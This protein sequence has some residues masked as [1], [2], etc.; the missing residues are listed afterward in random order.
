MVAAARE[1]GAYIMWFDVPGYRYG[2][3]V[4]GSTQVALKRVCTE[5]VLKAV[6]GTLDYGTP[7][8]LGITDDAVGFAFDGIPASVPASV[9]ERQKQLIDA[10]KAGSLVLKAGE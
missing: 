3:E 9:I 8:E 10:V 5:A 6:E 4:V 7:T 1:H 2:T